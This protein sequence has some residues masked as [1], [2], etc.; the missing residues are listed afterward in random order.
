MEGM[1]LKSILTVT[2]TVVSKVTSMRNTP[3]GLTGK[4]MMILSRL[5]TSMLEPGYTSSGWLP[6]GTWTSKALG[7]S[8]NVVSSPFGQISSEG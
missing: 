7:F 3:P 5:E 1:S 8:G 2:L 4:V 6:G